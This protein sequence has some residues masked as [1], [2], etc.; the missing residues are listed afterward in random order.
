MIAGDWRVGI[1]EV[2]VRR[3]VVGV[4]CWVAVVVVDGWRVVVGVVVC[5][6]SRAGVPQEQAE[7]ED[8]IDGRGFVGRSHSIELSGVVV[9]GEGDPCISGGSLGVVG[10]GSLMVDG[11]LPRLFLLNLCLWAR[12]NF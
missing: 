1:G 3:V 6:V 11:C 12:R 4:V 10:G 8:S 5:G 9:V 7:E 2:G